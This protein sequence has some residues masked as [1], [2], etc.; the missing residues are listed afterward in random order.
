M[1]LKKAGSSSVTRMSVLV[2]VAAPRVARLRAASFAAG[3]CRG[4]LCE[5]AN[6][7]ILPAPDVASGRKPRRDQKNRVPQDCFGGYFGII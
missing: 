2:A 4:R 1:I 5:T 6:D 7:N 3:K